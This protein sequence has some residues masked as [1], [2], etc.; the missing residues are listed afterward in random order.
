MN[1]RKKI[2]FILATIVIVAVPFQNT[3][4]LSF[5]GKRMMDIAVSLKKLAARNSKVCV[6]KTDSTSINGEKIYSGLYPLQGRQGLIR[7]RDDATWKK[8]PSHYPGVLYPK[9]CQDIKVTVDRHQQNDVVITA[10]LKKKIVELVDRSEPI[11]KRRQ[12]NE[13]DCVDGTYQKYDKIWTP[14]WDD[15]EKDMKNFQK[16]ER[17]DVLQGGNRLGLRLDEP[18][19]YHIMIPDDASIEIKLKEGDITYLS[20]EPTQLHIEGSDVNRWGDNGSCGGGRQV[21]DYYWGYDTAP[22]TKLITKKGHISVPDQKEQRAELSA[23]AAEQLDSQQII[24][25][26]TELQAML[27]ARKPE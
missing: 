3:H 13:F 27:E 8:Y 23:V 25:K 7:V 19:E 24:K 12:W 6:T 2:L 14:W 15:T 26:I 4:T 5:F 20:L 10:L 11:E 18:G 21:W 17:N 1:S 16:A 9:D 22:I